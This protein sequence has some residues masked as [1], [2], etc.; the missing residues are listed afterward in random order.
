MREG[1]TP[2]GKSL[3]FCT[4]FFTVSL[5]ES[6]SQNTIKVSGACWALVGRRRGEGTRWH[7]VIRQLT[8]EYRWK[9]SSYLIVI[10]VTTGRSFGGLEVSKFCMKSLRWLAIPAMPHPVAL[11]GAVV[12]KGEVGSQKILIAVVVDIIMGTRF[13]FFRSCG[14]LEGRTD[15]GRQQTTYRFK[16]QI[17][18]IFKPFNIQKLTVKQWGEEGSNPFSKKRVQYLYDSISAI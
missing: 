16:S 1:L 12:V 9:H 6:V 3:K 13:L 4:F 10:T 5:K 2:N 17:L 7:N 18:P 14:C 8:F 15:I 11:A